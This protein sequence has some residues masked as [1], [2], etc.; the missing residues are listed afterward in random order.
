MPIINSQA[1]IH[2]NPTLNHVAF[3]RIGPIVPVEIHV[4]EALAASLAQNQ[5][6]VPPPITG[7]ALIDTGGLKYLC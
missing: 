4:P 3:Q 6:T 1:A 2:G 5:T 7:F